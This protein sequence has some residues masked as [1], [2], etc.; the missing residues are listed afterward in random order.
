M[1]EVPK[2]ETFEEIVDWAYRT[3]PQKIRNLSDFP[4]IQVVDEPPAEVFRELS[5]RK[6]WP[7]GTE[8]RGLFSG[9]PRTKRLHNLLS[10]PELIFVFRGPILR[11]SQGNL[12]AVV[13]QTVWHEVAHWLGHDE[14]E[15]KGLGL[16]LS[17]EELALCAT[18]GEAS[19][20]VLLRRDPDE[21][22]D[23]EKQQPRCVKCYSAEVICRELD[24]PLTNSASSLS[25]PISVHAKICRCNS[26]GYEWD[27]EDNT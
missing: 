27:D 15:V 13:K 22:G 5:K 23:A 1:A 4:G 14:E 26:C 9:V 12:R 10:P 20:T 11:S 19:K 21:G 3:L 8:L 24:K 16:S 6:N 2:P 25:D 7:R 18:E 17:A